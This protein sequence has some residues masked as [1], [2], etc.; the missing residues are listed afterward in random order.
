[1]GFKVDVDK[2]VSQFTKIASMDSV[3]FGE[4]EVADYLKH[5]LRSLGFKV[6]EDNI[7]ARYGSDTG[8]IYAI[9]EASN[10]NKEP[11]LFS[12]H[13]DTV[14]PG[15]GKM[16]M[17]DK[18]KGVIKSEGDT[19]LGADD[20][21]GIVEI[22]EGIRL[23][24]NAPEGH[25]DIEV[26]FTIAEEVYA[27]GSSVLDYSKIKSR[28]AFVLDLEGR[29]GT[30]ARIAPSIITFEFVVKGRA[31]HAGFDPESGINAIALASKIVAHTRQG[32]VEEH[33]V[34]NVGS[35]EG[36]EATNIVSPYCRCKGETRSINHKTAM[37][38]IDKLEYRV[39]RACGE[40]GAGYSFERNVMHK[41][42]E[43]PEDS[44]ACRAFKEACETLDLEGNLIS[45][46]GGSDNNEFARFGIKGIVLSCGMENVHSTREYVRIKDLEMGS[47]LVATIINQ[48]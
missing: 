40:A 31:A 5:E 4:R 33:L 26:L 46:G 2:V 9:L 34:F 13:M 25:G 15:I 47:K 16:P 24:K 19:V 45:T 14:V 1:M 32:R 27:K 17:V 10:P 41:A 6:Q 7:G 18:N 11:V 43:T 23:A 36:G 3:S 28:T 20:V 30:A 37:S 22:L 42:Y 48:R 21:A 38:A 35:I 39:S 12:A 8:N 29:I 44:D